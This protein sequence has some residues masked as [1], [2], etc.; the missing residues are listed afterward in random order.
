MSEKDNLNQQY[1][2]QRY[3]QNRTE[4][5]VGGITPPLK[6]YIDQLPEKELSILVPGGGNGYEAEYLHQNGFTNVYLLDI[7][8]AP[9]QNFQERLPMFPRHHL[10][11]EDFFSLT[12]QQ[13]DLVLEQTFFCALPR[14]LRAHYAR[15][16]FDLLKPN[17]KLAGVLFSVEFEKE[18]P[19][20]GGSAL[21]YQ[22]Y[23]EPYFEFLRF[24]P[25]QNSV[26][27][28]QGRELFIE[29]QRR[30]RPQFIA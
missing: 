3:E 7:A 22:A 23:F 15:Q 4:W 20:F 16:M 8:A 18:G 28:R 14:D 30:S 1:W 5:D 21:E 9:L 25:C 19:P 17:G 27:P 12:A 10:L 2:Q 26:K 29:L 13:Y 11:Q 6:S 24:E